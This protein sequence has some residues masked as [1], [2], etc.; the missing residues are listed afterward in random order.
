MYLRLQGAW[1]ISRQKDVRLLDTG[2]KGTQV[3]LLVMITSTITFRVD[4]SAHHDVFDLDGGKCRLSRREVSP[5]I[6][7]GI[8]EEACSDVRSISSCYFVF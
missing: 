3:C 7:L 6:G 5:G 4:F 8:G 1:H 2:K